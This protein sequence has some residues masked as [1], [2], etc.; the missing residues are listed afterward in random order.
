VSLRW[1]EGDAEVGVT[2]TVG[3]IGLLVHAATLTVVG[4]DPVIVG[5]GT[6]TIP[7]FASGQSATE[8]LLRRAVDPGPGGHACRQALRYLA[9]RD[10][11]RERIDATPVGETVA[12]F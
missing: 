1:A 10:T 6:G 11:T 3:S 5:L 12:L 9:S 4:K 7:V 2:D 8:Y